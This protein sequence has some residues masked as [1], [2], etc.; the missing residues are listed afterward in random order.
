MLSQ[1]MFLVKAHND[2]ATPISLY[3]TP[4]SCSN[5]YLHCIKSYWKNNYKNVVSDDI[6]KKNQN[7]IY[8]FLLQFS[9]PL[10]HNL[11]E[12]GSN[13]LVAFSDCMTDSYRSVRSSVH[14]FLLLQRMVKTRSR[15]FH[16][17]FT[18]SFFNLEKIVFL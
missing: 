12:L 11:R 9:N 14:I 5:H 4:F 17:P 7:L 13:V 18:Q 16:R 1:H 6:R 15:K 10:V 2:Q 3:Y 8:C